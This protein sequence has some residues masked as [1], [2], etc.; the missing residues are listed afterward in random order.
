MILQILAIAIAPGV[1][2]SLLIYMLDSRNREPVRLLIR[3]FLLGVLSVS[4]P[5]AIQMFAASRGWSASMPGL[6]NT[7]IYAFGV[8]GLSEELGKFLVLRFYAYPKAEFDEP[9]D[10]IVYSV[11]IGMG[12]A[13][14]EN[15]TYVAQYGIGTG[16]ARMFISVPAH[17]AFA[18]LMGYYTGLAKFIPLHRGTLLMTGLFWAVLFHGAYDFFLFIGDSVYLMLASLLCFYIAVRLSIRAIK[19]QREISRRWNKEEP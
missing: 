2:I 11:M 5:L 14:A 4:F 12:F 10:G 16:L 6:L 3:A 15:I 9:F 8:V 7:A 13:T 1:A 18:V 17:A 19:H